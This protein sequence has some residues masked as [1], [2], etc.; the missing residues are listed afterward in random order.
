MF[1][2]VCCVSCL[3]F[4]LLTPNVCGSG[5]LTERVRT[6]EGNDKNEQNTNRR[7]ARKK[8]NV[9]NKGPGNRSQ[10]L[11]SSSFHGNIEGT[12]KNE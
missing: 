9:E 6:P 11:H 10:L 2:F 5:E 7:T 1:L 3:E 8:K 12:L 4:N